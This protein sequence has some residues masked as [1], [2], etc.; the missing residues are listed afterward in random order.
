MIRFFI[1]SFLFLSLSLKLHSTKNILLL[2]S[3]HPG[4]TWTDGITDG[5]V[6]A[7]SKRQDINLYVEFEDAKRFSDSISIRHFKDYLLKK[8]RK[9]KFDLII[10][11]DNNALDFIVE[12]KID[13]TWGIPVVFCGISNYNDYD[14]ENNDYYGVIETDDWLP[15]VDVIL[16]IHGN[17]LDKFYFVSENTSTGSI[18][19]S[20]LRKCFDELNVN[21]KLVILDDYTVESLLE[22]VKLIQGK[23]IVYYHGIGVDSYGNPVVPEI[24]GIELAKQA[25]V[26]V[27]SS[28]QGIIGMGVV[29]G[30]VRS[31]KIHGLEAAE[32]AL[33]LLDGADRA[34]IP[35]TLNQDG[36]Y[37]F[38]FDMIKKFHLDLNNFPKDAIYINKPKKFLELYKNETLAVLSFIV[39][40]ITI[41]AFLISSYIKRL[42]AEKRYRESEIRFREFAELLPQIVFEADLNGK[43][44]FVNNHALDS[45]GYTKEELQLGINLFELID[46][47]DHNRV[48]RNIGNMIKKDSLEETAYSILDRKGKKYIFQVHANLIFKDGIPYGV[49][50]IGIEI[51]K[52]R[53]FEQDLINAKKRAEESDK[54]KSAFLANMSHEI[55]TPLNSIVGFSYLLS[56]R[57]LSDEEVNRMAG[58]IRSS[59][60]HLLMLINDI[61]DISKIEAQQLEINIT[62]I[63]VI[64]LLAEINIYIERE[65]IRSEKTHINIICKWPENKNGLFIKTDAL[66][67]KQILYNLINNAL[68]FTEKGA[69]EFGYHLENAMITF[70]VKDSGIGIDEDLGENIFNR[71]IKINSNKGKLYSGFG[72]GLSISK[73]LADLLNGKLWYESNN[74]R[75]TTFYFSLPINKFSI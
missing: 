48:K 66:R 44:L 61:I 36:E 69:I 41:I 7:F 32:L 24:L 1:Y 15:I 49:R 42:R 38:D 30:F 55:R 71:F 62:N 60:D 14:I 10:T 59:S 35:R 11:S 2:N 9:Y 3:Y 16:R 40:L 51:T 5:V 43:F 54:L 47:E 68:K 46:T 57:N 26:P 34:N 72:L 64:E 45:F 74:G 65:K 56:E 70:F 53:Q 17:E 25:H 28:Y 21:T 18:R 39:V 20:V 37:V 52:Q 22:K 63:D 13:K 4:F 27:Y 19:D 12:N 6:E 75:G 50:G 31:G 23:S 67:L 58:Y 8:Y 29:G 33:K 73:Q